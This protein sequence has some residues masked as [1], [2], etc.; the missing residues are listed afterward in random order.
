MNHVIEYL[1]RGVVRSEDAI[2]RLN[3]N[4]RSLAKCHCYL[5]AG[6]LCIGVGALMVASV[7]AEQDKE[8]ETLKKQVNDLAA[9]VEVSEEQEGA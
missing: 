7:V 6:A 9:K 8:I 4:V 2:C 1:V 3:K 5:T